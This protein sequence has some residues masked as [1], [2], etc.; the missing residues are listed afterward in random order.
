MISAINA[1]IGRGRTVMVAFLVIIGAGIFSYGA[2]PKQ[3]EPDITF[4]LIFIQIFLEGSSPEDVERLL[5]RPMEQE[6]RSLEGLIKMKATA[7]ES[8]AQINLEFQSDID[9]AVALQ[10]VRERVD[11]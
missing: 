4:P 7:G 6:L 5:I 3:A 11:G 9:I 2:L 1:A 8:N 10:N